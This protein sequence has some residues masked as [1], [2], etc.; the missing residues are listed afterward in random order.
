MR[1]DN[2]AT[3]LVLRTQSER[4]EAATYGQARRKE[5]FINPSV[6]GRFEQD[7]VRYPSAIECCG[8]LSTFYSATTM[9]PIAG[10]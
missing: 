3:Q 7:G 2:A 9:S 5:S 10:A 8:I 4:N 6:D 1:S